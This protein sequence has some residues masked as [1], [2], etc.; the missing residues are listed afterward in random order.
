MNL[1]LSNHQALLLREH[2]KRHIEHVD[3]ELVHTDKRQL[4]RELAH[5]EALLLEILEKLDDVI[6]PASS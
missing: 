2:L 3:N 6:L 4:Q 1:E 5:D